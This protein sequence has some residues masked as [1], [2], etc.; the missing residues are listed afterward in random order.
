MLY[1]KPEEDAMK[2][3]EKKDVDE[4]IKTKE[5]IITA[6]AWKQLGKNTW[7]VKLPSGANV[8]LKQ[9]NLFESAALGHI[10]LN[11]VNLSMSC[12]EKMSSRDGFKQLSSKELESMIELINKITLKAVVNPKVSETEEAGVILLSDISVNDK[13][14]IFAAINEVKEGS[15]QLL[16]F[17]SK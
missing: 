2:A 14:A 3:K 7:I 12:A 11:L 15:R 13:F 1:V 8:E 5:E 4:T 17:S 16:P 10:P 6:D 9:F